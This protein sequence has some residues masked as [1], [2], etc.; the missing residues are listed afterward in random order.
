MKYTV[1][2]GCTILLDCVVCG[3]LDSLGL[4]DRDVLLGAESRRRAQ[5]S[6]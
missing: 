3:S 6:V 2:I 5:L 4:V 1:D